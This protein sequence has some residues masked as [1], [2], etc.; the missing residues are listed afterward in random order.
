MPRSGYHPREGRT[1]RRGQSSSPNY[2]TSFEI[3][4]NEVRDSL[5]LRYHPE[6]SEGQAQDAW[7]TF[8]EAI[9]PPEGLV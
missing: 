5:I 6:R 3:I 4:P 1:N 7:L 9:D 2:P 8:E